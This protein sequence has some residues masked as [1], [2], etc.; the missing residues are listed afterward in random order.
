MHTCCLIA[1]LHNALF[2]HCTSISF[3]S[4]E[5]THRP[6][7]DLTHR[8]SGKLDW[9]S[10][11]F[12]KTGQ[13]ENA[14]Y[15]II[16]E[17]RQFV[18]LHSSRLSI[19]KAKRWISAYFW[20]QSVSQQPGSSGTF[21]DSELV[22]QSLATSPP[23]GTLGSF[24]TVTTGNLRDVF[25]N[26]TGRVCQAQGEPRTAQP[27]RSAYWGRQ[28]LFYWLICINNQ[29]QAAQKVQRT[30]SEQDAASCMWVNKTPKTVTKMDDSYSQTKGRS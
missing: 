1:L 16:T 23:V 29:I 9:V 21:Q 13:K 15:S 6:R 12:C 27:H 11:R 20:P 25:N 22:L 14:T 30:R 7:G 3:M 4:S 10:S 5:L 17:Q 2:T 18:W 26:D 28:L 8:A 24:D 19:S